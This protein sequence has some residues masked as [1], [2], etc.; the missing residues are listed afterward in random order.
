MWG[1]DCRFWECKVAHTETRVHAHTHTQ[2]HSLTPTRTSPHTHTYTHRGLKILLCPL[3]NKNKFLLKKQKVELLIMWIW[4][5]RSTGRQG[6]MVH[7]PTMQLS[8]RDS[9]SKKW[10]TGCCSSVQG[11]T[12]CLCSFSQRLLYLYLLFWTVSSTMSLCV[13]VCFCMCVCVFPLSACV[14]SWQESSD[15]NNMLSKGWLRRLKM[16]TVTFFL[17]TLFLWEWD[18]EIPTIGH[19]KLTGRKTMAS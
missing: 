1:S 3:T 2:L 11:W 12:Q 14:A 16:T 13:W 5:L 9:E 17:C 4:L 6:G 8:A 19:C 15:E 7:S 10:R 18:C